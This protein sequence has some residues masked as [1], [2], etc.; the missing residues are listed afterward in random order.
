MIKIALTCVVFAILCSVTFAFSQS[1]T[2]NLYSNDGKEFLGCFSCG[3]YDSNSI[4]NKYGTY[5]SKYSAVSIWNKYGTYG[6]K[7]SN[8]SPCNKYAF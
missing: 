5:G 1:V 8:K 3:K 7:Y 4:W 2:I 6:G